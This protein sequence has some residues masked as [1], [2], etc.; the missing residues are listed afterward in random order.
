MASLGWTFEVWSEA[1]RAWATSA[2]IMRS[3]R[4]TIVDKYIDAE[5][6][7][8]AG[9]TRDCRHQG[10]RGMRQ[11]GLL[12]PQVDSPCEVSLRCVAAVDTGVQ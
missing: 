8:I 2:V 7:D 4:R 12:G 1:W 6:I 3:C 5:V 9:Q 11:S 10:F